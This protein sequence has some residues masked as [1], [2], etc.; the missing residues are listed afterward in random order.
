MLKMLGI[1]AEY[2]SEFAKDKAWEENTSVFKDQFYI[3]GKQH[4]KLSRL[5]DKVD[6]VVTDSPLLN[7]ILYNPY[8]GEIGKSFEELIKHEFDT[9]YNYNFLIKRVKKYNPSGRLQTEEESDSLHEEIKLILNELNVKYVEVDGTKE[10]Y[11]QI[12]QTFQNLTRTI[13]I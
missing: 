12:I 11:N 9:F 3:F 1:N 10:G 7:S 13:K 5:Q 2:V 8:E 6:V 4:Y